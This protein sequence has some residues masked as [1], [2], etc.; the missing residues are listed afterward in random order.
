MTVQNKLNDIFWI[1]ECRYL[2]V[3]IGNCLILKI[4]IIYQ[5]NIHVLK[6]NIEFS[7]R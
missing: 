7:F 2:N 3:D 4:H 5:N 6:V 1:P